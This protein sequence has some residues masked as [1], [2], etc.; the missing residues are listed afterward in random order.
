LRDSIQKQ[1][2]PYM[3]CKHFAKQEYFWGQQKDSADFS[4]PRRSFPEMSE[5]IWVQSL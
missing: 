5:S 1:Q 3:Y 2:H 4:C